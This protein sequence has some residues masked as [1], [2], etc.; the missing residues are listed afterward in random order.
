[1]KSFCVTKRQFELLELKIFSFSTH[2]YFG[3]VTVTAPT[4]E[5]SMVM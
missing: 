5:I 4:F 2:V 1:M 3:D